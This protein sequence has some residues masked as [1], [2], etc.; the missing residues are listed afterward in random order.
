MPTYEYDCRKC[1]EFEAFRSMSDPCLTKCPHCGGRVQKVI[2]TAPGL[3][4]PDMHWEDENDGRGRYITQLAS[5]K[6]DP[7]AYC[8]SREEIREK[9]K[10]AGFT[11]I[12]NA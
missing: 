7:N 12:E 5:K 10:K 1:G 11:R 2:L 6:Q 9:A 3:S 8:R 4:M